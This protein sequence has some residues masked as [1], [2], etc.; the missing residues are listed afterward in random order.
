MDPNNINVNEYGKFG[1]VHNVFADFRWRSVLYFVPVIPSFFSVVTI[2]SGICLLLLIGFYLY[3]AFGKQETHEM[4]KR[5]ERL[6]DPN[7]EAATNAR[8]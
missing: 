3:I 7:A 4:I 2:F 6:N 5:E 8:L 1:A